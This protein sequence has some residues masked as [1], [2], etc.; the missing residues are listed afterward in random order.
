VADHTIIDTAADIRYEYDD[1]FIYN[2]IRS[3]IGVMK[4][5]TVVD[6]D[7]QYEWL[8]WRKFHALPQPGYTTFAYFE[9][10]AAEPL[11]WRLEDVSATDTSY[12]PYSDF[13][14]DL[15]DTNQENVKA[16][17]ITNTG[18]SAGYISYVVKYK[19]LASE[20][21]THQE[22]VYDTLMVRAV[23]E[24]S[25]RK[26][27]RRTMNLVW[28]TGATQSQAQSLVDRAVAKYAEPVPRLI[29]QLKGSDDSMRETIFSAEISDTVSVVCA[30]L[31][32]NDEFY[33]DSIAIHG[34]VDGIPVATW[35]LT[36]KHPTE[37]YSIFV[38]DSSLLDGDDRLG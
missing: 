9:A 16:V 3:S 35:G 7:A 11:A 17:R 36:D 2:D 30:N 14:A 23:D 27:G 31:G 20:E 24:D 15:I 10:T 29:V 18:S 8:V 13:Q 25:I 38:L 4:A 34:T 22:T 21:I 33:I 26:Y 1:R 5:E 37:E 6:A 28:P 12:Q 32:L 19:Y